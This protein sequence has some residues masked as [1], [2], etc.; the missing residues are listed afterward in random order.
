MKTDKDESDSDEED[1]YSPLFHCYIDTTTTTVMNYIKTKLH[2]ALSN[3]LQLL[4]L[5]IKANDSEV[6]KI[7]E[8][9]ILAV[10]TSEKK[11]QK[12]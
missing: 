2:S 12:K 3:L 9:R 7:T 4:E 5:F 10:Q 6:N 11:V 1:C 8:A